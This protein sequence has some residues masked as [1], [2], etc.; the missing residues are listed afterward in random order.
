MW[1]FNWL[2][3]LWDF[4]DELV[5][6]GGRIFFHDVFIFRVQIEIGR[7]VSFQEIH[8]GGSNT[9]HVGVCTLLCLLLF[10]LGACSQ[11]WLNVALLGIRNESL[12]C[13]VELCYRFHGFIYCFCELDE[14]ISWL[15]FCLSCLFLHCGLLTNY[16]TNGFLY[17]FFM[18]QVTTTRFVHVYFCLQLNFLLLYL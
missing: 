16:I 8:E 13:F 6:K 1:K 4:P 17:E 14:C 12:N 10:L 15:V 3:G 9:L 5:E 11:V 2:A 7:K 18:W